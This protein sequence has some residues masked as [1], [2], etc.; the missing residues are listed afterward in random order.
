MTLL[1]FLID[2][3]I[4]HLWKQSQAA[5]GVFAVLLVSMFFLEVTW[6]ICQSTAILLPVQNDKVALS[7]VP[8]SVVRK[9]L[10]TS[11]SVTRA[12]LIINK[13]TIQQTLKAIHTPHTP[14]PHPK[15]WDYRCV[16]TCLF[17]FVFYLQNIL[18]VSI[19]ISVEK[20]LYR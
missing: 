14:S 10:K 13:F 11:I 8:F 3:L 1:I 7:C 12:K 4:T 5:E 20:T 6:S 9:T 19:I 18:L 15:C 17:C 16:L 2:A